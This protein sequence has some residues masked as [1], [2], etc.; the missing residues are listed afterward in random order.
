MKINMTR[1]DLFQISQSV[2]R[3]APAKPQHA[4]LFR[5]GADGIVKRA[6]RID[7]EHKAEIEAAL[8]LI[9][10]VERTNEKIAEVREE[11][12]KTKIQIDIDPSEL[13]VLTAAYVAFWSLTATPESTMGMPYVSLAPLAE[14]LNALGVWVAWGLGDRL[15]VPDPELESM[16][17]AAKLD[18]VPLDQEFPV[19]RL[20][21]AGDTDGKNEE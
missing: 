8:K 7:K 11:K 21:D 13:Q 19:E 3:L 6:K 2:Q 10:E 5:R 14:D 12:A 9:P 17:P 15:V 18:V 4:E 1:G 16:Y 20:A